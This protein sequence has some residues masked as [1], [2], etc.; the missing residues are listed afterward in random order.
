VFSKCFKFV[1]FNAIHKQTEDQ[2][3]LPHT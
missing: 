1:H 2:L 3:T